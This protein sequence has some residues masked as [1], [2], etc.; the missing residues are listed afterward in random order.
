MYSNHTKLKILKSCV[1]SVLLY[2]AEMWRITSTDIEQLDV[3]HRKCLR[4]IL[5]IFWPHT[6]SNCDL[7]ERTKERPISE[8]VKVRRWRWIGHILRREKTTIAELLSPGPLKARESKEDPR[9]RGEE[10]WK[11]LTE[12]LKQTMGITC[13][14]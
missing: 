7:Y 10:L 14:A 9:F 8:T 12:S 3:F 1:T 5:G 2:G 4:R 13:H 11:S 6:I